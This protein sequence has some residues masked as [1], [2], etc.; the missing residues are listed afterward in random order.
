MKSDSLHISRNSTACKVLLAVLLVFLPLT[1][2]AGSGAV[3]YWGG[4]KS[5]VQMAAFVQ[6]CLNIT[7][8]LVNVIATLIA[9]YSCAT[10]YIKIQSGEEG[11]TKQVAMLV[12]SIV[13]FVTMLI[14]FP[15]FFVNSS[16]GHG[17]LFDLIFG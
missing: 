16:S 12:G 4:A 9:F 13:Y 8:E 7:L 17:G 3:E 2:M 11:F 10:I 15:S 6:A 5:L 14:V 1:V